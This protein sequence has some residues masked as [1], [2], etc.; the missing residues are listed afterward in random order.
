[1]TNRSFYDLGGA[2]ASRASVVGEHRCERARDE[3][4]LAVVF[5]QLGGRRFETCPVLAGKLSELAG[6]QLHEQGDLAFCAA[7]F[8]AFGAAGF[9]AFGSALLHQFFCNGH[10]W[11][12]C[13][14]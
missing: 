13:L 11:P 3:Q 2:W 7:G 6:Q 12:F 14:G 10:G 8:A 1:M 9:A 5:E 4:P